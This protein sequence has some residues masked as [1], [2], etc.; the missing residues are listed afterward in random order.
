[1]FRE[2]GAWQSPSLNRKME[3]LW[4][5]RAGK[6][7]LIFP[8]SMGRFYQNEDFGLVGALA[9]KMDAGEIQLMCVDSVD[10]ESWYNKNIH[11]ADRARRHDQYD[12]YVRYEVIPYIA[13]RS[14]REDVAVYGASFGAY[15]AAN[16][17][18]RHPEL[19]SKAILFSGLYDIHRYLDE[20]WDETCYFHCPTAYIPNLD[21][22]WTKRLARVT[23]IIATGEYDSLFHENRQFAALLGSKG[24]TSHAEFWP[25]VFGHDWPWWQE[26]LKRFLP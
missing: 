22:S 17:A 8:T 19:I 4:F 24:I 10:D 21:E 14:H 18:A 26:N 2:Y 1:M 20:Y 12:H 23:W 16:L 15:H 7:V 9:D 5:G 13:A 25:G 6:P 3:F 11:P